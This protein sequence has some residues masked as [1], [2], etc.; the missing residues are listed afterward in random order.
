M[1]GTDETTNSPK[2]S[3]ANPNDNQSTDTKAIASSSM[4]VELKSKSSIDNFPDQNDSNL[5]TDSHDQLNQ[6]DGI[7]HNDG[8]EGFEDGETGKGIEPVIDTAAPFESV[9]E[10]VSKFGGILDWKEV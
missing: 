2:L 8:S 6:D 7:T 10:A 3:P 1:E 5:I 9:K 4:S